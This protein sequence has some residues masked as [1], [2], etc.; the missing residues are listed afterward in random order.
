[1]RMSITVGQESEDAVGDGP[2]TKSE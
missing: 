1:V 2:G